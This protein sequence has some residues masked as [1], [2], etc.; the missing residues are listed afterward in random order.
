MF[1]ESGFVILKWSDIA[2]V[3]D[4]AS[5]AVVSNMAPVLATAT[6]GGVTLIGATI[7]F[8]CTAAHGFFTGQY[9][10]VIGATDAGYNLYK[11]VTVISPTVFQYAATVGSLPATSPDLGTPTVRTLKVRKVILNSA[12]SNTGIITFGPNSTP[13]GPNPLNPG[14]SYEIT[15][16]NVQSATGLPGCFDLSDWYF[17]AS[18]VAQT[19]NI[20]YIPIYQIN[21]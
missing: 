21:P 7:N 12:T 14:D 6:A 4:G 5:T 8:V 11:Q 19:L 16:P 9:V 10:Q 17:K 15:Q 20:L 1:Q 2:P 18:V 13:T 3:S